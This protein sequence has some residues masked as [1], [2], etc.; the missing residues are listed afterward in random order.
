MVLPFFGAWFRVDFETTIGPANFFRFS[1]D[2]RP[3]REIDLLVSE[4]IG[5]WLSVISATSKDYCCCN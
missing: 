4:P 1:L 5:P 2:G 3:T